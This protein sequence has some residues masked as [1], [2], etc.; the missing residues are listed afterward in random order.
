MSGRSGSGHSVGLA[1]GRY[2]GPCGVPSR[3][4]LLRRAFSDA[5]WCVG[6]LAYGA[7]RRVARGGFI[8]CFIWNICVG[9]CGSIGAS[10]CRWPRID[11]PGDR[12]RRHHRDPDNYLLGEICRDAGGS[13]FDCSFGGRG[14]EVCRNGHSQPLGK[15]CRGNGWISCGNTYVSIHRDRS[16]TC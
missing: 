1:H 4:C 2:S 11:L 8:V 13:Y 15:H 10:Q 12:C 3:E 16:D 9:L 14:A 7:P 6:Q 5:F